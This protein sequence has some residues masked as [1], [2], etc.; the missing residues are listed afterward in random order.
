MHRSVASFL[1]TV[2]LMRRTGSE[3]WYYRRRIPA[4]VQRTFENTPKELRPTGWYRTHISISLRTPDRAA[5]RSKAAELL[6][7]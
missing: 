1:R 2:S 7:R 6:S 5:A 3:N 4:D